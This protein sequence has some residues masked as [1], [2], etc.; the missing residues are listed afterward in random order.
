M[1]LKASLP[2][3]ADCSGRDCGNNGSILPRHV[4]VSSSSRRALGREARVRGGRAPWKYKSNP[5]THEEH[6]FLPSKRKNKFTVSC[7][8]RNSQEVNPRMT[9]DSL[10]LAA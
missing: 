9:F 7:S 8:Q 1:P 3:Q 6:R 2:A 5:D 10:L 4:S